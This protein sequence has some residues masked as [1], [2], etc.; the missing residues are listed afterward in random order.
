MAVRRRRRQFSLDDA[1][2]RLLLTGWVVTL[3]FFG[4]WARLLYLQTAK[5]DALR[6]QAQRYGGLRKKTWTVY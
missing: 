3:L 1:R 6:E 2:W 4:A 5:A